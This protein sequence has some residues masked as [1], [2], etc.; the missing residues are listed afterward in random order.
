[1]PGCGQASSVGQL[2]GSNS[3]A[4]A[5]SD[6]IFLRAIFPNDDEM[7][8]PGGR[9]DVVLPLPAG[10]NAIVVP[11]EPVQGGQPVERIFA[12]PPDPMVGAPIRWSLK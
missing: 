12:V 10:T 2:A 6:T 5:G 8:L 4:D 3:K 9:V 7:L 1:M 11:S